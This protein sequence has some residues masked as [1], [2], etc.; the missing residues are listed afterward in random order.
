MTTV[1]CA[2]DVGVSRQAIFR[3]IKDKGIPHQKRGLR[4]LYIDPED[5]ADFCKKNNIKRKEA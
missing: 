5:W 3:W 2:E 4:D 1:E